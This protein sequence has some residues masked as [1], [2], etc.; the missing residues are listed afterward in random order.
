MEYEYILEVPFDINLLIDNVPAEAFHSVNSK[1]L[2]LFVYVKPLSNVTD[3]A[4]PHVPSA[5]T[6]DPRALEL[7][8]RVKDTEPTLAEKTRGSDVAENCKEVPFRDHWPVA[9]EMDGFWVTPDK[10]S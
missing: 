10:S 8:I 2:L 9:F 7:S 6:I 4:P 5:P 1:L 3:P